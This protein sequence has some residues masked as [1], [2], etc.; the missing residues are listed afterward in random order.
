MEE[1]WLA[2]QERLDRCDVL[3][4][5]LVLL[6]AFS[7]LIALGLYYVVGRVTVAGLLAAFGMLIVAWGGFYLL[8]PLLRSPSAALTLRCAHPPLRFGY[9]SSTD[10]VQV[11]YRRRS[12]KQSPEKPVAGIPG[13]KSQ[14]SAGW[15]WGIATVILALAAFLRFTSAN[16][17]DLKGDEADVLL[18]SIATIYGEGQPLFLHTK[19]PGEM[20][21]PAIVGLLAGRFD[22]FTVR[23]PFALAGVMGVAG[24]YL[25]GRL[26]FDD[27]TA[28]VTMAIAAIDGLFL[29]YARTAQY[30]SLVFMF[31]VWA[32]YCYYH[33]YRQGRGTFHLA[34]T[35]CLAAAALTHYE[36][37]LVAPVGLYL[38]YKRVRQ[39]KDLTIPVVSALLFVVALAAFYVPFALHPHLRSTTKYLAGRIGSQL[40]YDNFAAFY[41][42]ALTYSSMYYV[43][44]AG[45]LL[46]VALV[47]EVLKISRPG[48]ALL[49]GVAVLGGI[50][51]L[52]LGTEQA[53]A[54]WLLFI[55]VTLL[56]LWLAASTVDVA[57][58][59]LLFW[60]ALPFLAYMFLVAR[61]GS[62]YYIY[63]GAFALLAGSTVSAALRVWQDLSL[64]RSWRMATAIVGGV[65]LLGVYAMLAYYPYMV[66]L[67]ND[68]EYVLTYPKYRSEFYVTDPRFPFGERIG[69][70]F[71]YRLGWQ[72][73]GHLYRTGALSGDWD[74]NDEG[75]SLVWY[76]LGIPRNPCFP[77][78]YFLG[79]IGYKE[80]GLPVPDDLIEEQYSLKARVWDNGELRLRI[81]EYAPDESPAEPIDLVE[82]AV[83][84]SY[85]TPEEFHTVPY[86][87]RLRLIPHPLSV[88]LEDKVRLVGYSLDTQWAR[89]GGRLVVTLYWQAT[90]R[91]KDSYKVFTHLEKERLWGQADDVPVCHTYPTNGW[92]VGE[93]V[94]DRH[95]MILPPDLP[96]GTYPVL[97]GMYEP[98]TGERLEVRDDSGKIKGNDVLLQEVTIPVR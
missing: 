59:T 97:V 35:L 25:L 21:V 18:G 22:E 9:R 60:V 27:I 53:R 16:Y 73:V 37:A 79:E 43:V 93:Y 6:Y 24:L 98:E 77:R 91:M 64:R 42:N 47:R 96:P 11:E 57:F 75:N 80:E 40:L 46:G 41:I 5:G 90:A 30:Q 2:L 15:V 58:K 89:P 78:Y 84:S 52:A 88:N 68:L 82:P 20:L 67:R 72:M 69:F 86:A 50:S 95:V 36:A 74:S 1:A 38:T 26:L 94:V 49:S 63:T 51:A 81:Y 54:A 14:L 39:R 56:A 92:E 55:Y 45:C 32:I 83:Y 66:Y 19:G 12:D 85:V 33:Y 44:L 31:V 71:P 48:L 62:H 70:G 13:G 61:P 3:L 4:L 65:A 8:H 29:H 10:R 7:I 34:G 87:D 23:F 76:T 17:A 28:V